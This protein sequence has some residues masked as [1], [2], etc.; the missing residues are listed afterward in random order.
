MSFNLQFMVVICQRKKK[1][2][3]LSRGNTSNELI[4]LLSHYLAVTWH[5]LIK[6]KFV[7][8]CDF[9]M[10]SGWLVGSSSSC[11]SAFYLPARLAPSQH[12]WAA[13]QDY[14]TET[15]TASVQIRVIVS[16]VVRQPHQEPGLW[17]AGETLLGPAK[18][19][20]CQLLGRRMLSNNSALGDATQSRA[21]VCP[22]SLL[23]S[24]AVPAHETLSCDVASTV[25]SVELWDA[26][27]GC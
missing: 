26:L 12:S 19:L 22:C 7:V 3:S 5:L 16:D 20:T 8:L 21:P 17:A 10:V 9:P 6:D 18:A 11:R 14:L 15:L 13:T 27:S 4:K 24:Q 2:L 1:V 23:E 25:H